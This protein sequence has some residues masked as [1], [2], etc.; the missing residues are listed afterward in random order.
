[1]TLF[2]RSATGTSR[3]SFF[4]RV[5]EFCSDPGRVVTG[6]LCLAVFQYI[7]VPGLV[8]W[9]PSIFVLVAVL[10]CA[11]FLRRL[12]FDKLS[13]LAVALVMI[14]S[15]Y[16]LVM[17][18]LNGLMSQVPYDLH[19]SFVFE[20]PLGIA[21]IWVFMVAVNT[22]RRIMA[23]MLAISTATAVSAM[24]GLL[25]FI[26]TEELALLHGFIVSNDEAVV[27]GRHVWGGRVAGLSWH[28]TFL[29]YFLATSL[30][31]F[32][33]LTVVHTGR[34]A[35]ALLGSLTW[36]VLTALVLSQTRA[37][38]VASMAGLLLL[39][40]LLRVNRSLLLAVTVLI[41]LV[42]SSVA[43][44]EYS[45]T[46]RH[47]AN[48]FFV[49]QQKRLTLEDDSFRKRWPVVKTALSD[50]AERPLGSSLYWASGMPEVRDTHNQF[51]DVLVKL[52]WPGLLLVLSFYAVLL[53]MAW[54][55]F[56]AARSRASRVL[57]LTA[58][59]SLVAYTTVSMAHI[60]DPFTG[61]SFGWLIIGLV[62]GVYAWIRADSAP[63][64]EA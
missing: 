55:S 12:P 60:L 4:G 64:R 19:L 20:T 31:M 30:P 45:R 38:W 2:R 28:P 40:P 7:C 39:A 24:F 56:R 6:L 53:R 11:T 63:L 16:A 48:T 23:V 49:L 25:M 50:F 61:D 21:T 33:G 10:V 42:A 59:G 57:M 14:V 47:D 3:P 52:G 62:F 43:V 35:R 17:T 26:W 1:M 58:T 51:L 32:A 27:H 5:H 46:H 37:A 9:Y 34:K 29:G 18:H 44:L 22:R 13:G 15:I 8:L 54:T 41:L 36:M